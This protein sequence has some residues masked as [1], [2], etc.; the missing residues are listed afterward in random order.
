MR[1]D[2][3]LSWAARH[4]AEGPRLSRTWASSSPS[5]QASELGQAFMNVLLTAL[6][7]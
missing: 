7:Q 2:G 1:R 6:C 4:S 5:R 3:S